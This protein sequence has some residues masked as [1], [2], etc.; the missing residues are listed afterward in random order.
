MHEVGQGAGEAYAEKCVLFLILPNL[1]DMLDFT[2][3]ADR[4]S[5][6]IRTPVALY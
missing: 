1:L 6:V 3:N 5:P 4:R 2:W